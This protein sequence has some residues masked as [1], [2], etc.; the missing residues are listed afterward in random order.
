[1]KLS[2]LMMS[3]MLPMLMLTMFSCKNDQVDTGG[4]KQEY[5]YLE[6]DTLY[7]NYTG[8]KK[9]VFNVDTPDNDWYFEMVGQ[10]D[11]CVVS[12]VSDA[13]GIKQ[14]NFNVDPNTG[15]TSREAK[16]QISYGSLS[17]TLV[18]VQFAD[19]SVPATHII[20]GADEY[21]LEKELG[22]LQ[23]P[24]TSDGDYSVS[25][26]EGGSWLQYNAAKVVDG[27]AVEEFFCDANFEKDARTTVVTFASG[28]VEAQVSV[29]QWG[30]VDLILERTQ[31]AVGYMARTDTVK[32]IVR[33]DYTVTTSASWL[34]CDKAASTS[35][36]AII[37]YATNTST[38]DERTGVLTFKTASTTATLSVKQAK[39]SE[40][41][42]VDDDQYKGDLCAVLSGAVASSEVT[43]SRGASRACDGNTITAWYT[44][45]L[46]DTAPSISMNVDASAL[47]QID[48]LRYVPTSTSMDWGQ[49]GVVDVYYTLDGKEQLYGTIDF[50][51][52]RTATTVEFKEPLSKSVTAVRF[53]IKS[54]LA[55]TSGGT[56]YDKVA[57]AAEIQLCQYN[58]DNFSPL[59]IFADYS[60]SSLKPSV[61]YDDIATIKDPFYRRIAEKVYYGTYDEFRVCQFTV[62]QH[63]DVDSKIFRTNTYSLL[64][65]VTGMY[66][67][68]AGDE[69]YIFL[70]EDY[71][72]SIYVRVVDW[73]NHEDAS[74]T[75]AHTFDYPIVKGR[76]VIKPAY[77]GLMYIVVH[78][79]DY[80]SIP[81]M[82]ANFVNAEINGYFDL[83]KHSAADFYRLLSLGGSTEPHFDMLS[84]KCLLNYSKST[85][86]TYTLA[87][88]SANGA[89]AVKLLNTYDSVFMIQERIQGHDKYKALGRDR[90]HKN[91][92]LFSTTYG[93]TYGF[94]TSYRTAYNSESM[95]HDVANPSKMWNQTTTVY[96]N[97]IVG[98]VW[99]LAHE[100]GHT[101]QVNGFVWRGLV[102]V[103]NNLM[104]AATQT[105]FYGEGNTTM[106]FNDHFNKGMRDIATRWMTDR[107]GTERRMTHCE[108]CNTPV[109]GATSDGVDPTTQLEPFW[110]LYLYYHLVVGR[111]DFYP[112]LYEAC[113]MRQTAYT[114]SDADQ[115]QNMLDFMKMASDAAGEDLSDFC[116]AWAIPGVN[117]RMKVT[118]YGTNYITTTAEQVEASK[119]YCHK[120]SKPK[121]NPLYINDLNLDMYRNPKPV[122]AGTHTVSNGT[123]KMSG[124]QNVVAW[125]LVDPKT[126]RTVAIK[127]NTSSFTYFDQPSVYM[128]NSTGT[129]YVYSTGSSYATSDTGT[130][131]ALKA[132]SQVARTDLRLYGVAADGTEV[133]SLSNK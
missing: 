123:Y 102:E 108:A 13:A 61:T 128:N 1:M 85:I 57:S 41:E 106:R 10:S 7:V 117:N 133:A 50:E 16:L 62:H 89:N 105:I 94:S 132:T 115:A 6:K 9:Q 4:K 3:A 11:W 19:T 87:G 127:Q 49:W 14:L 2:K 77:R 70:D 113:R 75:T 118:H 38:S 65:N 109:V 28:D 129:D 82:K 126:S 110:Q 45:Y 43:S 51:K 131:R 122:V 111:T 84:K 95:A 101:N 35:E 91:R 80:A 59:T 47:T 63:P 23:I 60:L 25:V 46:T 58:P 96:N 81:P 64:D 66:V 93:E 73:V 32:L 5:L 90:G 116:D 18:V 71:G 88:S 55:T 83:T 12:T 114:N 69:Q 27:V 15:E 56:V 39:K 124:W 112:D 72:Q 20:P 30:T 120:Y 22:T 40:T 36:Y 34:S 92:M 17:A 119:S 79:N 86:R 125:K 76:N 107:D 37:K 100:L 78:S 121:L 53:V 33:G 31:L 68:K 98:S 44:N 8:V 26:A 104:C 130:M 29:T 97:N 21:L 74:T 48:Y 54:A 99:G 103:T 42:A 52:R 67:A 24:V